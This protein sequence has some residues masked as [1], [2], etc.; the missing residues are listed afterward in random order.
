MDTQYLVAYAHF[1]QD[2]E[3]QIKEI[4]DGKNEAHKDASHPTVFRELLDSD[5]PTEEKTL[6]RLRFEATSIVS[7]G[8]ETTKWVLSVGTYHVLKN[9]EVAAKLN[10]EL[11]KTWPDVDNPPALSELEKLPYL[12]AVIQEGTLFNLTHP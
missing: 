1:L 5:L 4:I 3:K 12:S 9:P 2:V 6:E 8:M 7:A 11:L 10:A